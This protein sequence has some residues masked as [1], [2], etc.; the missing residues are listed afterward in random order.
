MYSPEGMIG[1]TKKR[2]THRGLGPTGVIMDW[3]SEVEEVLHRRDRLIFATYHRGHTTSE[4]GKGV[5]LSHTSISMI[6]A[7]RRDK[8]RNRPKRVT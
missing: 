7:G 6:L 1:P 2:T 5:G 4:V 8:V 3:R